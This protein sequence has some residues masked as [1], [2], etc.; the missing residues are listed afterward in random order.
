MEASEI[1]QCF[2]QRVSPTQPAK[3][4]LLKAFFLSLVWIYPVITEGCGDLR[5]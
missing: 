1:H 2:E 5:V 4:F 3:T